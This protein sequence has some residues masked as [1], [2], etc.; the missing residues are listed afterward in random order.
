MQDQMFELYFLG[1]F[2]SATRI[3]FLRLAGH[4]FDDKGAPGTS[5][6]DRFRRGFLEQLKERVESKPYGP[7]KTS[8]RC[9]TE[10]LY[11]RDSPGAGG[12]REYDPENREADYIAGRD[13]PRSITFDFEGGEFLGASSFAHLW[14]E[15]SLELRSAGAGYAGQD[16]SDFEQA[17]ATLEN[18]NA[19]P[20][21]IDRIRLDFHRF[22]VGTY[23]LRARIPCRPS[24]EEHSATIEAV[25]AFVVLHPVVND[26]F[27]SIDEDVFV[28][29]E[30]VMPE[31]VDPFPKAPRKM[32]LHGRPRWG[33]AMLRVASSSPAEP[34]FGP[35]VFDVIRPRHADGLVNMSMVDR[36]FI[37][38]GWG[39]TVANG[40]TDRQHRLAVETLRRLQA[41]WRT[42][43]VLH[44]MLAEQIDAFQ[45]SDSS[46][47]ARLRNIARIEIE[48]HIWE[49]THHR[50]L[51]IAEPFVYKLYRGGERSWAM[52]EMMQD[53]RRL[54]ETIEVFARESQQRRENQEASA[55]TQEA[56]E[57]TR[58]ATKLNKEAAEL[59]RKTHDLNWVVLGIGVITLVSVSSDV[60]RHVFGEDATNTW[61]TWVK[62]ASLSV[63][64]TV[65]GGPVF[66]WMWMRGRRR[67]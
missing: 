65:V 15:E 5:V 26:T 47:E 17:L 22:G 24:P 4:E 21:T 35:H 38:I 44:A 20:I 16:G 2:D 62:A 27:A 11:R 53:Y 52:H 8:F 61:P 19:L 34:P 3:G 40:V 59:G 48:C 31:G 32:Q 41:D 33:H 18:Y 36:A 67:A 28:C 9:R 64:P 51:R 42:L 6:E 1:P 12:E 10:L 43:E 57:V 63:L 14:C 30:A 13:P 45:S 25:H 54:L 56:T 50:L 60:I 58:E 66:L 46:R 49:A 37:H 23:S 55:L 29:S 7:A 39:R